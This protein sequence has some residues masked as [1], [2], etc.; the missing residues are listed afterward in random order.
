MLSLTYAG[1]V[2]PAKVNHAEAR[3]VSY[4]HFMKSKL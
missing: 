2:N 4:A 3:R 1:Q